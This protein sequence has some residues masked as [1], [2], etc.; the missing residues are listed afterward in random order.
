MK[1]S[2]ANVSRVILPKIYQGDTE[3]SQKYGKTRV[4]HPGTKMFVRDIFDM[5]IKLP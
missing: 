1:N 5:L 4:G 2:E 3:K